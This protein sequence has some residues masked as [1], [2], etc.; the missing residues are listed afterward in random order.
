M[1]LIKKGRILPPEDMTV[2]KKESYFRKLHSRKWMELSVWSA[3]LQNAWL[4]LVSLGNTAFWG[5]SPEW[6]ASEE[7]GSLSLL[8]PWEKFQLCFQQPL[9]PWATQSLIWKMGL[10]T[11]SW[12]SQKLRLIGWFLK[13]WQVLQ[14]LFLKEGVVKWRETFGGRCVFQSQ[15]SQLPWTNP[16]PNTHTYTPELVFSQ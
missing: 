3:S 12:R 2:S 13:L 7:V 10:K 1:D 9:W 8:T 11:C 16:P 5:S 14:M 6:S 15:F 4:W